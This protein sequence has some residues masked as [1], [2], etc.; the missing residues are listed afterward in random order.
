MDIPNIWANLS[1]SLIFLVYGSTTISLPFLFP[2]DDK[3]RLRREAVRTIGLTGL[4]GVEVAAGGADGVGSSG[5]SPCRCQELSVAEVDDGRTN[6]GLCD[7]PIT[8]LQVVG[9][10]AVE[11]R[12]DTAL[13]VVEAV[14][15]IAVGRAVKEQDTHRG[16]ITAA[17]QTNGGGVVGLLDAL[18]VSHGAKQ[19]RDGWPSLCLRRAGEVG[20]LSRLDGLLPTAAIQIVEAV[21]GGNLLGSGRMADGVVHPANHGNHPHEEQQNEYRLGFH[22]SGEPCIYSTKK[23]EGN[24]SRFFVKG[25]FAYKRALIAFEA[26]S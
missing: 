23:T 12:I 15:Q 11:E 7:A 3:L 6:Q 24:A 2:D 22:R 19:R 1:D 25:R 16:L 20:V 10:A 21:V 4:E 13:L 8:G 5:R 18:R 14:L 17:Q 9:D 26:S